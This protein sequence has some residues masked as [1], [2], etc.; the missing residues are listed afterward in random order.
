MFV[1]QGEV[2]SF[3]RFAKK[4]GQDAK[5]GNTRMTCALGHSHRSKLEG[6][7]CQM[8]QLRE[9][10]GELVIEQVEDHVYLTRARIGYVPDFRCRSVATGEVFWVEAK[11]YENDRWPMKKKLWKHYGPGMLEIWKGTHSR[12][13]L[14][15]TVVPKPLAE[16]QETNSLPEPLNEAGAIDPNHESED[17]E[18]L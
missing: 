16:S 2:V 5:M 8:L 15:E 12:P 13:V 11:G 17:E 14:S 10:A 3:Y 9:K 18:C 4:R 6:A 7:V 1:V